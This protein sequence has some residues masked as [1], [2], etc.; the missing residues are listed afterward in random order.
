MLRKN[1]AEKGDIKDVKSG[2]WD[3]EILASCLNF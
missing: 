3:V 1:K 2:R